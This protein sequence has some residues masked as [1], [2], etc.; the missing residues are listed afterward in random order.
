[1]AIKF[2]EFIKQKVDIECKQN[3]NITELVALS[4]VRQ[5][6]DGH[7]DSVFKEL[8]EKIESQDDDSLSDAEWCEQ[9]F[10]DNWEFL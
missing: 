9:R 6:I 7:F 1:M 5:K 10:G 4:I 8:L 3:P 2:T